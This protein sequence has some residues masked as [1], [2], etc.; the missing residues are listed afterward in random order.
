MNS[1]VSKFLDE[2]EH[3]LR[4]E[5]DLL[6]QVILKSVK[7]LAEDIKWNSP[8]YC[9]D[10]NDRITMRI[11]PPNQI[12]LILHRGAKK[13]VQPRSKLI[14]DSSGLLV[15]KEN[16]RAVVTLKSKKDIENAKADLQGIVRKWIKA[17]K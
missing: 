16:D 13:L 10:G 3:P 7:G 11:Q 9:F 2:L 6:R 15:W 4:T 8:N 17:A 5:I 1:A 14:E 12:Q